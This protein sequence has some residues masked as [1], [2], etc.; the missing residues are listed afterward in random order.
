MTHERPAGG[1]PSLTSPASLIESYR[2]LAEVFHD[3]L[4]E[5]SL[6]ALLDRVATALAELVPH[7]S[8][9]VYEADEQRRILTP[10]LA[11]DPWADKIMGSTTLFGRGITGWA[12][13]H[14]TPVLTNQAH[15][16]PRVAI[17]PGT[18]ADEPEALISVPLIARG[19]V[20]GALN[21]YRL[22]EDATFDEQEFELAQRFGD[23]AALALDN[24]QV[25]ARL[26]REAQTDPLTGL[27]NHRAYYD[28]LRAEL[29]RASRVHDT[30]AVLMFDID[31]FKQ[32]NDIYGHGVGDQLLIWLARL[33]CESVRGSDVVCRLGGEEFGVIMP[34]CGIGD[35]VGLARRIG[36]LLAE[37][38]FTPAG[39]I[40]VSV[41]IAQGP[42]HAMNPR[43]LSACAEVAMMTAK[44][45]GKNRTVLF[46]EGANE[47]PDA[48]GAGREVQS[49]AHLKMLRSLSGKLARLNDVH[50]ICEAIAS[51]LRMLVDYH[52]CRVFVREGDD[53]LPVAYLGDMQVKGGQLA[54]ALTTR[55]GVGVTGRVAATGKSLLIANALECEFSQPIPGTEAIDESLLAV[56]LRYGSRV[57][58]VITVSKLGL[59]QFEEDDLR[60][61]E[62]LAGH[63][64][65]ALENARLYAAQRREAENAKALLRLADEM[66]NA[67]TPEAI[68]EE[69]AETTARLLGASHVALWLTADDGAPTCAAHVPRDAWMPLPDGLP[70]DAPLE[71]HEPVVGADGSVC[72]RLPVGEGVAGFL[73]V[74]FDDR[75]DPV[76]EERLRLLASIAY[77][78]S[79]GLQ[80]ARLYLIQAESAEIASSLL[81]FSHQLA[82]A[83]GLDPMLN[84]VV[85]L[86][87]RILGSTHASVWLED[88]RSQ[89]LVLRAGF[90][91]DEAQLAALAAESHPASS[92]D[93]RLGKDEVFVIGPEQLAS[94]PGVPHTQ[95]GRSHAVAPF[96]IEGGR[97]GCLV[98]TV[99]SGVDERRMR[100]L[101][102]LVHQAKLAIDGA[103]MVESLERTF[104]STVEALAN[105]LEA[106]DRYTFSH[107]QWITDTAVMVGQELGLEPPALKRVELGALF[108]DLGRIGLPS[109]LLG[110][111]GSLTPAER[112]VIEEHPELGE[113][114]LAPIDRLA[115]VRPIVRACHERWDGHGYP[116]GRAGETIPI[117]ARIILVCD[118]FHAM[119]SDRPYRNRLSADEACRRL[120][121]ASAS[122]FDPDVVGAFLRLVDSNRLN[123][124]DEL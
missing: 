82:A 39:K 107:G 26:E 4:S 88:T 93:A 60:L 2:R 3:V 66:A 86:V 111:P 12:V 50:Q 36:D 1:L 62:V 95:A 63:A 15:R 43:E 54:E 56:P 98:A 59:D 55:V 47:R 104:V 68:A 92:A 42:E 113:K 117:E 99:D 20:K 51:E 106:N 97:L 108:H 91:Y 89:D 34:S 13:E 64:S 76:G 28:R 118:A 83:Q 79:M 85:Q 23:A 11:R 9:I 110:K 105:A 40:T 71:R 69:A 16:D 77:Q 58:G 48:P 27:H 80:K 65:V 121:E 21:I 46:G 74:R 5:Q 109:E 22:G 10:L 18:P 31:D 123:P 53:L 24:A 116:D 72:A 70:A 38:P 25:R 124:R 6:D 101:D 33:V 8:L 14:R 122:Q 81:E 96:R 19:T 57:I 100:L 94:L 84:R 103:T 73:C 87:A 37:T 32:V 67:G 35:A 44:A 7:D 112:A 49:V 41:G 119:T 115:E 78:V 75:R 120:R 90:G 17:V 45:Q 114:I 102:G 52:S 29:Q 61:L 30:V